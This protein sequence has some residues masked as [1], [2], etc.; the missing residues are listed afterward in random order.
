MLQSLLGLW[1]WCRHDTVGCYSLRGV[2]FHVFLNDNA[3]WNESNFFNPDGP[4]PGVPSN[5]RSSLPCMLCVDW[6]FRL[7]IVELTANPIAVSLRT[8]IGN[9][10]RN[11]YSTLLCVSIANR[12]ISRMSKD[13]QVW[14]GSVLTWLSNPLEMCELT[15]NQRAQVWAWHFEAA[16]LTWLSN[17]L[18]MCEPTINQHAHVWAH[19]LRHHTWEWTLP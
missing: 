6:D 1:L 12:H 18:E 9:A 15:I 2:Y 5:F 19:I 7:S 4:C 14:A 10:I 13:A 3:L 16:V 17:P 8:G 11:S